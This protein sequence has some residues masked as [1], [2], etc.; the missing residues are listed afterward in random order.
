LQ[1]FVPE[2]RD[3]LQQS[4]QK[5]LADEIVD[6]REY[7][8]L[9]KDGSTFPILV[10]A[11][12][13]MRE[14]HAVGLRGIGV[15]ITE[16]KKAEEERQ[17]HLWS[18]ESMEQVN[19]VIRQATDPEQMLS[20]V[21]EAVGSIF[22]CDRAWLLHPCDPDA[23]SVRVPVEYHRPEYPGADALDLEIPM[24]PG[25]AQSI[26]DA[27]A[28][29][30]PCTYIAGTDRP[31]SEETAALFG[32][33]SQMLTAVYP[34]MGTPWMF[35]LHQCSHARVWTPAEQVLF[36][37][38]GHR[39]ADGLSSLLSLREL[40][41]SEI[42]FR[43]LAELL[44]QTVF[45]MDVEGRFTFVSHLAFE[46]F[47]YDLDELSHLTAADM[48]IPEERARIRQNLHKKLRSEPFRDHEY[49]ASWT[50]PSGIA[51]NRLFR[52]ARPSSRASSNRRPTPSL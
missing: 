36:K 14:G 7:R 4:V 45:E 10:Y 26:R 50:S 17:A 43:D 39:I 9:R 11:S 31:V 2:D 33:Q 6:N 38:I 49:T 23:P 18:L 30:E 1:L 5:R 25:H 37:E 41:E 40:K 13:I 48:F 35:G 3:R 19:R 16:Q 8:A 22:A 21:I 32:V 27:L 15:D 47:G 52:R 42:R 44:P 46:T 51:P 20:D 34:K 28:S 24:G 29:E 12:A